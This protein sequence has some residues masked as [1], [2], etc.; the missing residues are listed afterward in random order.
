MVFF[1]S[2]DLQI[3]SISF[4]FIFY[5]FLRFLIW[6]SYIHLS[7]SISQI[8]YTAEGMLSSEQGVYVAETVVTKN[9]KLAKGRYRLYEDFDDSVRSDAFH[10]F[11]Y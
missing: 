11:L 6:L 1:C 4:L 9:A 10:F 8:F 2:I 5:F 3:I 7:T